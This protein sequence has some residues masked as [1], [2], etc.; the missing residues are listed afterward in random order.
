MT[1]FI[2]LLDTMEGWHLKDVVVKYSLALLCAVI[3]QC[4]KQAVNTTE[5]VCCVSSCHLEVMC[6]VAVPD[7]SVA[8]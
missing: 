1:A 4:G 3:P 7:N 5:G 6:P 2:F 8:A